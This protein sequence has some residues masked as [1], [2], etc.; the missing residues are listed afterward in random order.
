MPGSG[1]PD[2]PWVQTPFFF[3]SKS[4]RFSLVYYFTVDYLPVKVG[5]IAYFLSDSWSKSLLIVSSF[6]PFL[7]ITFSFPCLLPLV[8]YLP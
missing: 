1:A 5:P 7:F 3:P 6:H 4:S 8:L 2:P